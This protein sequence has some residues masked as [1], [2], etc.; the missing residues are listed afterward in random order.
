AHPQRHQGHTQPG[1]EDPSARQQAGGGA[2]GV[3]EEGRQQQGTA[4]AEQRQRSSR[5]RGQVS[6]V[7]RVHS[8]ASASA[9][10]T[11]EVNTSRGWA[12]MT[13]APL[14]R[15]AGVPLTP[16]DCPSAKSASTAA[17]RSSRSR[18]AANRSGSAPTST[19][20]STMRSRRSS[21]APSRFSRSR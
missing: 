17:D 1:V 20:N 6:D 3:G 21:P 7:H 14:T 18:S 11:A 8:P 16:R 12:P 15:K 13:G 10:S 9:A 5:D 4:R 19:A 2:E